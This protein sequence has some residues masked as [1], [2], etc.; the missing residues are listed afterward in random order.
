MIA[1][2]AKYFVGLGQ[3]VLG[4][5]SAGAR[6]AVTAFGLGTVYATY[7]L[8]RHVGSETTGLL[9]AIVVGATYAFATRAV[10]AI[11]DV[12]LT[13]FVAVSVLFL[14]GWLASGDRRTGLLLGVVVAGTLTTKVYGFVYALPIGAWFLWG[15]LTGDERSLVEAAWPTVAGGTAG[16]LVTFSPYLVVPHPP[17]PRD[18]GTLVREILGLPASYGGLFEQVFA[19][20]VVGNLAYVFGASVAHNLQHVG[21]GHAITV[22]GTVYQ[23]PPAWTY[24]YWLPTEYGAFYLLAFVLTVGGGI[25]SLR[26]GNRTLAVLA[27]CVLVPFVVVSLLTVKF[28]RY[29]LPTV[30]LL[31]V[32]G[33]HVGSVLL[34]R[35]PRVGAADRGRKLLSVGG[36]LAIA[37]LVAVLV[38]PSAVG[39]VLDRSINTDTGYDEAASHIEEYA[40]NHPDETVVV[41][42]YHGTTLA[43]YLDAPNVELVKFTPKDV[44]S[45]LEKY[46]GYRD[47]VSAGQVAFVVDLEQ[48]R[49]LQGTSFYSYVRSEGRPALTVEQS[50]S[51]R[52]LVVYAFHD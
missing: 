20:P 19:L 9:A 34:D 47:R 22:A 4:Q 49:R 37:V 28:P 35:R 48:N 3:L 45:N 17:V 24:L 8:G 10:L 46:R 11:L 42:S 16:L 44:P 13:F 14:L 29:V 38:P 21:S 32:G 40:A 26:R 33:I 31:A 25:W 39:P 5:T 43:Y 36:L 27:T 30:P 50:P 41:V 1:P 23:E 6:I 52:T 7:R 2:T 15:V 12:P 51:G 18:Y